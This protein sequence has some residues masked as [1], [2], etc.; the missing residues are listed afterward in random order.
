MKYLNEIRRELD[1]L[2]SQGEK[3]IG[4]Q[5]SSDSYADSYNGSYFDGIH[6]KK[7]SLPASYIHENIQVEPEIQVRCFSYE[8]AGVLVPPPLAQQSGNP[9]YSGRGYGYHDK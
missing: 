7:N 8:D 1:T 3:G 9:L 5:P 4:Y 2:A 6:L